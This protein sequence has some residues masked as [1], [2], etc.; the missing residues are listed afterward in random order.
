MACTQYIICGCAG[1]LGMMSAVEAQPFEVV[2]QFS[3]CLLER[4]IAST[5]QALAGRLARQPLL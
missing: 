3:Q 5:E 4:Y 1:N 2:L